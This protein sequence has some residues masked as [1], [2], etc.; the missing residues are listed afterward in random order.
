MTRYT[1]SIQYSNLS[2]DL[3]EWLYSHSFNI[4]GNVLRGYSENNDLEMIDL[5]MN[6]PFNVIPTMI[7]CKHSAEYSTEVK[8][9]LNCATMPAVEEKYIDAEIKEKFEKDLN[10]RFETDAEFRQ[11]ILED[12]KL[13]DEYDTILK[14]RKRELLKLKL[15]MKKYG[16]A[17]EPEPGDSVEIYM[18]GKTMIFE[19]LGNSSSNKGALYNGY[20]LRNRD[21]A[22]TMSIHWSFS[23]TWVLPD[24]TLV[25]GVK[26]L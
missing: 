5:L 2:Q 26:F 10:R 23:E 18:F 13:Q 1:L 8:R 24:F 22:I 25:P 12:K 17:E 4:S 9:M 7:V 3:Y 11:T 16:K 21:N 6:E 20:K 15:N 14:T 19:I